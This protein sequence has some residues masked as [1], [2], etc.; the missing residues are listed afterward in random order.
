MGDLRKLKKIKFKKKL[1]NLNI[2]KSVLL[3]DVEFVGIA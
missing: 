2:C 1:T 3:A